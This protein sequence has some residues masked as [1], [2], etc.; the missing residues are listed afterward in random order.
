[1][2]ITLGIRQEKSKEL[3]EQ[4]CQAHTA[5][6]APSCP[7]QI[8]LAFEGA[9]TVSEGLEGQAVNATLQIRVRRIY[10]VPKMHVE[11]K[12]VTSNCH[13]HWKRA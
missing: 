12:G 7:A 13:L 6:P 4:D 11:E 10:T 3:E 2:Q 1:M 5:R 8:V 9:I